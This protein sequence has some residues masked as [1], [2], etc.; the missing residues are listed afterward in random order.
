MLQKCI[1]SLDTNVTTSTKNWDL[2]PVQVSLYPGTVFGLHYTVTATLTSAIS[3]EAHVHWA[4]YVRRKGAPISA[5]SAFSLTGPRALWQ[6]N[7]GNNADTLVSGIA[8][9]TRELIPEG[10]VINSNKEIGR[11]NTERKM[12]EGDQLAFAGISDALLGVHLSC[13]FTFWKRS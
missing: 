2:M 10:L 13:D 1:V 11:V 5:I 8:Y 4:I 7:Q 9:V 12:E 6:N 3:E